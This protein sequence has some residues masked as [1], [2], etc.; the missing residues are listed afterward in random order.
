VSNATDVH[1]Q[2]IRSAAALLTGHRR[3]AFVAEVTQKLC[4]DSP[5][6]AE[7]L[8]G[9]SRKTATLGK[10]E[11]KS[12]VRCSENFS[13]RG[14]VRREDADP[15]LAAAIIELADLHTQI[16]PQLKTTLRYTRL[17][18]AALRRG[19]IEEKGF[20]D[21]Q[22]PCERS[23]RDIL[24]RMGYRLKRIQKTKPQKRL[25]QT[26]AIFENIK[27]CHEQASKSE[28]TLEISIDTKAKVDLGE[29]SRDGRTRTDAEGE[30]P[31]ALDHDMRPKKRL[32]HSE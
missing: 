20:T 12:G 17:T 32:C 29:Y 19:L 18:A 3:R 27:A 1:H 23:L 11:A 7:R 2:L 16:D 28:Q 4:N 5:R 30:M 14:R 24:N 15:K 6:K 26:D 22:L 10:H 8:F 9:F 13:A 21:E 25:E 31:E